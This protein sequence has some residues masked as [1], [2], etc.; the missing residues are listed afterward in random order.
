MEMEIQ[1]R[2]VVGDTDLQRREDERK[3]ELEV[4]MTR[5]VTEVIGDIEGG[6]RLWVPRC[7]GVKSRVI[8]S[9]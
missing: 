2:V 8:Q 1:Y 7:G 6:R 9:V 5:S 3:P 4:G